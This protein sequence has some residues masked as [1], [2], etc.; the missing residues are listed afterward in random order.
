MTEFECSLPLARSLQKEGPTEMSQWATNFTQPLKTSGFLMRQRQTEEK[1]V[2]HTARGYCW[3]QQMLTDNWCISV[4][5]VMWN[6]NKHWP[7]IVTSPRHTCVIMMQR[8]RHLDMPHPDGLSWQRCMSSPTRFLTNLG[9]SFD[10]ISLLCAHRKGVRFSISTSSSKQVWHLYFGSV[11]L[12]FTSL[13]NT[14]AG[15]HYGKD[16]VPTAAPQS[17][18]ASHSSSGPSLLHPSAPLKLF[19]FRGD[20]SPLRRVASLPLSSPPLHADT[21]NVKHLGR[22]YTYI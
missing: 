1:E 17:F 10:W 11:D 21:N 20:V 22:Y 9:K 7:F 15:G 12:F 6:P 13:Q 14:A 16:I 18:L 8:N 4:A 2:C 19:L 3:S 5:P